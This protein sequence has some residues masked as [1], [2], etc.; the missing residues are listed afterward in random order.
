MT[1]VTYV[2]GDQLGR[3]AGHVKATSDLVQMAL[4][5]QE[6]RVY[7]VEVCQSCAWNHLTVSFVLGTDGPPGDS[8]L[9]RQIAET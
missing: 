3:V 1:H 6:F 4:E 7:V 8:D 5:Y 9:D 2:Y